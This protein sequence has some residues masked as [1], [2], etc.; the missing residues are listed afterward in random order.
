MN[1]NPF[2]NSSRRKLKFIAIFFLA[3]G[4]FNLAHAKPKIQYSPPPQLKSEKFQP[5]QVLMELSASRHEQRELFAFDESSH[6]IT[7]RPEAL[8]KY[9]K[10][11]PELSSQCPEGESPVAMTVDWRQASAKAALKN[12][13][14]ISKGL[15]APWKLMPLPEY[16]KT[17]NHQYIVLDRLQS[18]KEQ[19]TKNIKNRKFSSAGE[20]QSFNQRLNEL[21]PQIKTETEKLNELNAKYLVKLVQNQDPSRKE[22]PSIRIPIAVECRISRRNQTA[23]TSSDSNEG[24]AEGGTD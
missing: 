13:E 14:A 17:I 24:S 19:L 16:G 1:K 5:T 23:E 21:E 3:S 2:P 9:L 4:L 15:D 7:I 22:K 6:A 12:A 18:E 8:N 10:S 11:H 20:E